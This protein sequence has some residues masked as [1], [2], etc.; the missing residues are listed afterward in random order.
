MNVEQFL[1]LVTAGQPAA[2]GYFAFD[3][4]LN[5]QARDL[6]DHTTAPQALT[7]TDF[8][9]ARTAGT[10][11]IDHLRITILGTATAHHS[12]P[13]PKSVAD[14]NREEGI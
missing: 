4:A 1:D 5:R 3:T 8:T 10:I 6:F 7:V 14:S 11:V 12:E 2:P 13:P 9:A